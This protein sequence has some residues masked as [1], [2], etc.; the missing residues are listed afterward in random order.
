MR[1]RELAIFFS[2]AVML[3]VIDHVFGPILPDDVYCSIGAGYSVVVPGQ[4]TPGSWSANN[5]CSGRD[6]ACV[7]SWNVS[8]GYGQCVHGTLW[9]AIAKIHP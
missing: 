2:V 7:T 6:P 8:P 1:W 3:V 5:G 9:D 4:V